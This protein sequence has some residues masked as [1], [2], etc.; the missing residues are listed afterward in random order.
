MQSLFNNDVGLQFLLSQIVSCQILVL[1]WHLYKTLA[2]FLPV[3]Q[4]SYCFVKTVKVHFQNIYSKNPDASSSFDNF[5]SLRIAKLSRVELGHLII[6]PLSR[7]TVPTRIHDLANDY[8]FSDIP[9]FSGISSSPGSSLIAFFM[10]I[11]DI[12]FFFL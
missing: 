6:S 5:Q 10:K 8:H 11:M 1:Y 2:S 4:S 12:I 9:A 3:K 7:K